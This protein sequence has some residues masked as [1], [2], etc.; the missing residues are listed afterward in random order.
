MST[1]KKSV[2]E[3]AIFD[4]DGVITDT[5]VIHFR[6]WKET[7][8]ALLER[9]EGPGFRPFEHD[10]DYVPYVDGKPRYDGVAAFLE[11]RGIELP[12]GDASDEPGDS[13]VCAVGNAKNKRFREIVLG[14]DIPVFESTVKIV[15]ELRE[16]GVRCGVASSSRNCRF[17]LESAG[18]RSRFETVVDGT[19]SRELGLN[20]K[21][22]PDIFVTACER[23]DSDP[24][25]SMMVEDAYSGVE[26]GRNG[27]FGFVLG[28]ARSVDPEG[29]LERGAHRVVSDMS[30]IGVEDIV[31][32]FAR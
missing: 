25:R 3:A 21:P 20:G 11:S 15:D 23:L 14:G 24:T 10:R 19:D 2:P 18:L 30:E 7:F 13:T 16:R 9:R 29:L 12:H 8:D 22:A 28:I 6:A 26:A 5:A 1:T 17:V 4:L 27:S 32:W 31:K